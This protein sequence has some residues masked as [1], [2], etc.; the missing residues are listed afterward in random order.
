MQVRWEEEDVTERQAQTACRKDREK[1]TLLCFVE[2]V[3]I[4]IHK[5]KPRGDSPGREE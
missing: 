5:S 3:G 4:D 1:I 2:G